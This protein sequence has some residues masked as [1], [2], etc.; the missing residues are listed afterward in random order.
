MESEILQ[1][2]IDTTAYPPSSETQGI[3][4]RYSQFENL[5]NK[6]YIEP[7]FRFGITALPNSTNHH[8]Q[9]Y[10]TIPEVGGVLRGFVLYFNT[11]DKITNAER[12]LLNKELHNHD[13]GA[14]DHSITI[15]NDSVVFDFYFSDSMPFK[16]SYPLK[17]TFNEFQNFLNS[18]KQT[19]IKYEACEIPGILPTSK[20]EKWTIVNNDQIKES[21][22][23][24]RKKRIYEIIDKIGHLEKEQVYKLILR[25]PLLE[26]DLNGILKTTIPEYK[27]GKK[28]IIKSIDEFIGSNSYSSYGLNGRIY[29]NLIRIKNEELKLPDSFFYYSSQELGYK[30]FTI[31]KMESK[32]ADWTNQLKDKN[33]ICNLLTEI[34]LDQDQIEKYY[35]FILRYP[36]ILFEIKEILVNF[37]SQN[38]RV[39]LRNIINSK[40]DSNL[41]N[42]NIL[43]F[44]YSDYIKGK[45]KVFNIKNEYY[46]KIREITFIEKTEKRLLE[47]INKYK[48]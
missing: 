13:L 48:E 9:L 18:A 20:F 11:I 4:I 21:Y 25:A 29:T 5:K 10:C 30:N 6:K 27:I 26:H 12:V 43:G 41:S 32:Y 28:A 19:L 38:S 2:T 42:E 8:L 31:E 17:L 24:N 39:I 15:K 33:E 37:Q 23:V 40:L 44:F 34:T 45:M 46:D 36:T 14:N 47:E 7:H 35:R 16:E 22:F 1:L 3:I